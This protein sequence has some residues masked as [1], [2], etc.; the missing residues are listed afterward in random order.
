MFFI[1]QFFRSP[2]FWFDSFLKDHCFDLT[3]FF[4]I[5]VLIWKFFYDRCFDLT[6]FLPVQR[7][8]RSCLAL[9]L[10]CLHGWWVDVREKSRKSERTQHRSK[11]NPRGL[12][13]SFYSLKKVLFWNDL[14]LDISAILFVHDLTG[15]VKQVT[16]RQPLSELKSWCFRQSGLKQKNKNKWNVGLASIRTE[17][18]HWRQN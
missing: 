14:F 15:R 4:K 9:P 2:V 8:R 17:E 13:N 1:W 16:L 18:R 5:V 6:V 7:I 10:L 12:K 11:K 3:V